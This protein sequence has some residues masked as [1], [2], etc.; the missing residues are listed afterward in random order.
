MN[1]IYMSVSASLCGCRGICER[2]KIVTSQSKSMSTKYIHIVALFRVDDFF[3]SNISNVYSI[4]H[5]Y[6][7]VF[8]M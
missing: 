4:Q 2:T 1:A 5:V 3:V 7:S 8:K 6:S